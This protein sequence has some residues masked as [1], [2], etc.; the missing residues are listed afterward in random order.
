MSLRAVTLADRLHLTVVDN[1]DWKPPRPD[2]AAHRGR[3]IALM[4][5]LMQDASIDWGASGT[6]ISMQARIRDSPR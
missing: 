6:T 4:R 1:G 2:P 3:G 5:A